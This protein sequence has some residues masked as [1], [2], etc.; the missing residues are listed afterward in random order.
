[1]RQ[2]SKKRVYAFLLAMVLA[3]TTF[4]GDASAI[5][6]AYAAGEN[7]QAMDEKF[8]PDTLSREGSQQHRRW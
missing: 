1:M 3:V 5:T 4:L 6:P 2:K 7:A 8:M